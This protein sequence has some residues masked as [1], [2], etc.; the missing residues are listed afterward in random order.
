MSAAAVQPAVTISRRTRWLGWLLLGALSA[1]L[2]ETLAGSS[3]LVLILPWAIVLTVPVYALHILVLGSV[4]VRPGRRVTFGAIYGAGLIFGLYEAYMTKVLWHPP[5]DAHPLR[6]GGFAVVEVVVLVLFWHSLISFATPLAIG[7]RLIGGSALQGALPR[8]VRERLARPRW[9][10]GVVVGAGVV[11]GG[12]IHS[13]LIAAASIAGTF[14]VLWL[15]LRLWRS[16]VAGGI[17]LV[18]LL[19]RGR[20][21]HVLLGLLVLDY[22]LF[23]VLFRRANLP[24]LRDQAGIWVLYA[25]FGALWWRVARRA[26][27]APAVP[28]PAPDLALPSP[29][30]LL[31]AFAASSVVTATATM[32][33]PGLLGIVVWAIAIVVGGSAFVALLR[34]AVGRRPA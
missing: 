2:A 30:R 9:V 34:E 5:W 3:P 31:V 24:P 28:P 16:R 8:F 6:L 12:M 22:A 13:P 4:V 17:P 27:A 1:A 11:H 19:P 20:E 29:R 15:L 33:A 23:G 7:E 21:W 32:F 26:P 14:L 10:V 25:A 18:D